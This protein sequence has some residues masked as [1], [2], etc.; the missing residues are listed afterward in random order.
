[1][2][3]RKVSASSRY[4]CKWFILISDTYI[5]V[6]QSLVQVDDVDGVRLHLC[7]A[8]NSPIV[9]LPGDIW[10]CRAK[11]EWYQQD[12]TLDSSTRVLWQFYQQSLS[13]S[14][15]AGETWWRKCW[16]LN[17]KYLFHTFNMP[18]HGPDS[19]TSPPKEAVLWIFSALKNPIV[20]GR[21]LTCEPFVQWHANH[22]TTEG[23]SSVSCLRTLH[24]PTNHK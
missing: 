20:L 1:M 16:I 14:N 12:K 23:D 21:V 10:V 4:H 17:T 18:Q 15:E 19:F 24:S 6:V 22:Y 3:F 9:H 8:T 2:R 5:C 7:V 13:S 11:M